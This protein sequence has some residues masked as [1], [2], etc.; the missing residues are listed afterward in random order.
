MQEGIR[1]LAFALSYTSI[2]LFYRVYSQ[3]QV[4]CMKTFRYIGSATNF[5]T[6]Y[7]LFISLTVNDHCKILSDS[8]SAC[9]KV[10]RC[11]QDDHPAC[12]RILEDARRNFASLSAAF[13][14]KFLEFLAQCFA[15][16][17]ANCLVHSRTLSTSSN[18]I[19]RSHMSLNLDSL[20]ATVSE[21][22]A[23]LA[24]HQIWTPKVPDFDS[25]SAPLHRPVETKQSLVVF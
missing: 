12:E 21:Y 19:G 7:N 10:T 17:L 23:R 18:L 15:A 1:I 5:G 20:A 8:E 6:I 11:V 24:S 9:P 16:N 14:E 22:G 13:R 3:G 2:R 25:S 4:S